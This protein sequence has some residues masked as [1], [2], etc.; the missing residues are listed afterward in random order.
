FSQPRTGDLPE[1]KLAALGHPATALPPIKAGADDPLNAYDGILLGDVPPT[2]LPPEERRRLERYV[3]ER[4]GTLVFLAG[5]SYFPIE[6]LSSPTAAEDPLLKMLPVTDPRPW[7]PL[8]GFK[9]ALTSEGK[10]TSFMQLEPTPAATEKRFSEFPKHFWGLAGKAKPGATILAAPAA[11]GAEESPSDRLGIIVQQNYGFGRVLL[12]GI[13]STWRWRYR[14]GDTYHHRFWGQVVR[15][16]AADKLLPGGNRFVRFGSWE[17][18]VRAGQNADIMV[19]LGEETPTLKAGAVMQVRLWRQLKVGKEEQ[20]ALVSLTPNAKWAKL[21][22]AQVSDLPPGQYRVE[23]DIPDL[24][25]QL[26]G[27]GAPDDQ[28][29][30]DWFTVAPPENGEMFDLA[31]DEN[32]L[33]ALAEESKGRL[34]TAENVEGLLDLF[35]RQVSKKEGRG[36]QRLWQDAPLVWWT[37]CLLLGLLT[38]EWIGRKWAGLP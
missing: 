16:A 9:L 20:A 4:G 24:R 34:F 18:V 12:V 15:W 1:E 30:R 38:F 6:Y 23:L 32:L 8:E 27:S 3:G 31:T 14:I 7:Q 21:L 13:D 29:R 25:A 17:P 28:P 26:A 35:A 19:R 5:K 37:F 2:Y 36:E 10:L 11:A 33:R 22:E